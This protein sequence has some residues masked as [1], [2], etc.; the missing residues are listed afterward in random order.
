MFLDDGFFRCCLT[1]LHKNLKK[2][3][4]FGRVGLFISLH[5]SFFF[6]PSFSHFQ[7]FF[8]GRTHPQF[9]GCQHWFWGSKKLINILVGMWENMVGDF[10]EYGGNFG[11]LLGKLGENPQLNRLIFRGILGGTGVQRV[12]S[13]DTRGL[14]P[15]SAIIRL[16]EFSRC[17]FKYFIF[18]WKL[19][20]IILF[21]MPT[22]VMAWL[23]SRARR[24]AGRSQLTS[25]EL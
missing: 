20:S 18:L 24:W 1:L 25:T 16:P 21:L 14:H 13:S 5:H 15:N 11:E 2:I 10:V 12:P 7:Y 3:S 22:M 6:F 23:D 19:V 4:P 9:C 8:S 17:R